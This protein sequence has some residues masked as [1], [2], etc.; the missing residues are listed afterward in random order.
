MS[1]DV[2]TPLPSESMHSECALPAWSRF[3][4]PAHARIMQQ[5]HEHM[6]RPEYAG[7]D[8]CE[9]PGG[10]LFFVMRH[11]RTLLHRATA[12]GTAPARTEPRKISTEPRKISSEPKKII[13]RCVGA[14][15]PALG[16]MSSAESEHIMPAMPPGPSESPASPTSVSPFFGPIERP[17]SPTSVSQ[18]FSEGY[19]EVLVGEPSEGGDNLSECLP[20][21]SASQ[22]GPPASVAIDID[23]FRTLRLGGGARAPDTDS[24]SLASTADAQGAAIS[25]A[26]LASIRNIELNVE[27][28][29]L[30]V[31]RLHA[32]LAARP[33]PQRAHTQQQFVPPAHLQHPAQFAAHFPA[34]AQFA[35]QHP[36]H[37]QYQ[38]TTPARSHGEEGTRV[39]EKHR[40][41]GRGN[42]RHSQHRTPES[43]GYAH[44]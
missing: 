13:S 29:Y 14:P 37:G 31:D 24:E 3:D 18:T 2:C 40:G 10:D 21:D 27:R 25:A 11:Y 39:P 34:N 9:G 20:D 1:G 35:A 38:F 22:A 6:S 12:N 4:R 32:G 5:V 16:N 33:R 28:L 15:G 7:R 17:A 30:H 44:G 26:M 19:S 42:A 41:R 8:T 36:A 43:Y 23:Y